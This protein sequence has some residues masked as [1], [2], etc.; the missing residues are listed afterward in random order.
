MASGARPAR[1]THRL[2]GEGSV[3]VAVAGYGVST[4]F[5]LGLELRELPY[6]L[7]LIGKEVA[8]PG[9]AEPLQPAYGGLGPP[10]P[11]RHRAPPRASRSSQ[12]RPVPAGSPR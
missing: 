7:A 6:V 1:H 9:N 4:P 10:T 2:A 5:P 12:P 11:A 8:H 3:V